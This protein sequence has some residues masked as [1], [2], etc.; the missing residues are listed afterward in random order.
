MLSKNVIQ[1]IW[2]KFD[3]IRQENNL[4]GWIKKNS[5]VVC[6]YIIT[7]DSEYF[8]S[9]GEEETQR[10]FKTAFNFVNYIIYYK[11]S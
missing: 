9:I 7:S 8:N 6:E 1:T 11:R 10:F 4:K 5:N 3:Q 2:K